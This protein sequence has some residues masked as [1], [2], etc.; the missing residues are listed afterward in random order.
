MSLALMS[1][2]SFAIHRVKCE[3][4]LKNKKA[5]GLN[6]FCKKDES[7]YSKEMFLHEGENMGELLGIQKIEREGKNPIYFFI[8]D[9]EFDYKRDEAVA[10]QKEAIPLLKVYVEEDN[11]F[12]YFQVEN[13]S[14][15]RRQRSFGD[16][17]G[18]FS[19]QFNTYEKSFE[20]LSIKKDE[21]D[22]KV[23]CTYFKAS[24]EDRKTHK[25]LYLERTPER[26]SN[27]AANQE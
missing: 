13:G 16:S 14:H 10:V 7:S 11:V 26:I 27:P 2:S 17:S 9:S 20:G 24:E 8:E 3:M 23:N 22:I 19:F 12:Y 21:L 15:Y 5:C 25:E 18:A 6:P 4:K 1:F